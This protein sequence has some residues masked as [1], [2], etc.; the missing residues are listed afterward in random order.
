M[1]IGGNT[2][3]V[4]AAVMVNLVTDSLPAIALA[5]KQLAGHNES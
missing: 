1:V 4:Y 2:P 5:W 3:A